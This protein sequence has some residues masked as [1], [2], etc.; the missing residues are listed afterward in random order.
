MLFTIR[1]ASN[2]S[3]LSVN[4]V[5]SLS[6]ST[7]SYVNEFSYQIRLLLFVSG[8]VYSP[9]FHYPCVRH[10]FAFG[11]L[12]LLCCFS[13]SLVLRGH[14]LLEA[15]ND[16]EEFCNASFLFFIRIPIRLTRLFFTEPSRIFG[17]FTPFSTDCSTSLSSHISFLVG[18]SNLEY[19]LNLAKTTQIA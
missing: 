15:S 3:S 13:I 14:C 5:L 10:N 9:V 4:F 18:F 6:T 11:F 7:S 19:A 2:I 1:R 12:S 16:I 8:P 17:C